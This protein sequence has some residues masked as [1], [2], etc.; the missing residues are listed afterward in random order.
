MKASERRPHLTEQE[1]ARTPLVFASKR[2]YSGLTTQDIA[3][4]Y[5]GTM[6]TWPDG[7]TL[8]PVLRPESDSE[9]A[10]LRAI[11][12]EVSQALTAAH[13]RPGVHIAITDQDNADAIEQITGAL[14]NSS[15]A[16]I[17]S[18]KRKLKVLALNG[19][20]PSVAALANNRYPYYKPLYLVLPLKPSE[21]AR[22]FVAFIL[23]AQG[24]RIFSDNGYLPL[25]TEGK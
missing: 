22:A 6:N 15:L 12:P 16:L 8:R 3:R 24:S 10:L 2:T 1:V 19:V 5:N 18:E 21:P 11:S 4:I 14:G 25:K 7:S 23:S 9:T 13:A 17:V 20:E